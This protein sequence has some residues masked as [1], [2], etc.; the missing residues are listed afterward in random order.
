MAIYKISEV[1]DR[2]SEMKQDNVLYADIM[3]VEGD[4][5]F[6]TALGF[7]ALISDYERVDYETVDSYPD[8]SEHDLTH[9]TISPNDNCYDLSFTYQEIFT[10]HHAVSNA[11]EYFKECEK[12]P[13]Y[14]PD[15]L[16][17]IKSSSVKCRNL[18]PKLLKIVRQFGERV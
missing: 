16:K 18:Q 4:S 10:L 11:L 13:S 7:E 12:N 9:C 5:E 17:R 14:T 6:P 15:I 3:E 8:V 1:L 2:L